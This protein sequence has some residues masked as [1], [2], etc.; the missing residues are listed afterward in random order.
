MKL[1]QTIS[2]A[3]LGRARTILEAQTWVFA[4]TMPWAPHWYSLRKD[5]VCDGDF[6]WIVETMRRDGYDEIYAERRHRV[7]N[8]GQFK[9]WTMEAP[10]EETILINR[11]P[12][13]TGG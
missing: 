1:E 13:P 5:W 4:R 7:M 8:V 3:D 2:D 10:V 12:V 11:K 9:Y 6:V